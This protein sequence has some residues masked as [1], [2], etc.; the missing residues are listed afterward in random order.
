MDSVIQP[1]N[2]KGLFL[3][4]RKVDNTIHWV[5]HYTVVVFLTLIKWIAIYTVDSVVQPSNNWG[6]MDS[7]FHLLNNLGMS[8]NEH[9]VPKD[10]RILTQFSYLHVHVVQ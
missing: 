4:V 9:S 3:V 1:S 5:N 2:N 10:T 8:I 6:Q 7:I